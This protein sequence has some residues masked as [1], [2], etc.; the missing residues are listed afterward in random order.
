MLNELTRKLIAAAFVALLVGPAIW[1]LSDA[2]KR[3]VEHPLLWAFFAL[4]GN[5]IAA[6]VYVLVRDGLKTQ[7]PCGSCGRLVSSVH[8]A[9]PWCGSVRQTAR[10]S[11]PNCRGELDLDWRFCPYCRTE[12]GGARRTAS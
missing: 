11:C 7:Q 8:G 9:C 4:F 12:V 2:R 1:V 5:V 10:R 6:L 3:G